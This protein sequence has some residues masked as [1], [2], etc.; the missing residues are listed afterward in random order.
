V[1]LGKGKATLVELKITSESRVTGK[2]IRE[3]TW[4]TGCVVASIMHEGEVIFPR[5]ATVLNA[6]DIVVGLVAPEAEEQFRRV[7]RKE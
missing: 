4:P 5:G 6:G 7:F 3:L 1:S 2:T